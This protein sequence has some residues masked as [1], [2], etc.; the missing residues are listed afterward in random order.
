MWAADDDGN[1]SGYI[2]HLLDSLVTNT[3]AAF[4][5]GLLESKNMRTGVIPSYPNIS[6]FSGYHYIFQRMREFLCP[7]ESDGK[8]K[9]FYSLFRRSVLVEVF[10][11]LS[12]EWGADCLLIF[13]A[14]SFGVIGPKPSSF[15]YQGGL[16]QMSKTTTLTPNSII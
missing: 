9:L 5:F 15:G 13:H 11:E 1:N 8:V 7:E 2:T 4:A 14:S 10:N 3:D 12:H 6:K 16:I